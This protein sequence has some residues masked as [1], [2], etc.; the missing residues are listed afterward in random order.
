MARKWRT[1]RQSEVRIRWYCPECGHE[2]TYPIEFEG[3]PEWQE[4]G[5][6]AV[7]APNCPNCMDAVMEFVR[8]EIRANVKPKDNWQNNAIQYPR[9]LEELQAAGVLDGH[10]DDGQRIMHA[11]C[12]SMDLTPDAVAEIFDRAAKDWEYIKAHTKDGKYRGRL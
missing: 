4:S 11:L 5:G 10:T 2:E 6:E 12:Q 1:A 3:A 7:T 9:M 8:I